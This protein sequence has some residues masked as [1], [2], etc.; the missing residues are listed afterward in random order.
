M[1]PK[2]L[3]GGASLLAA[4]FILALPS[5]FE[6]EPANE[7]E[8]IRFGPPPVARLGEAVRVT[9]PVPRLLEPDL[10]APAFVAPT[11]DPAVASGGDGD[12][13]ATATAG[14]EQGAFAEDAREDDTSK[15]GDEDV[16]EGGSRSGG[17]DEDDD[18]GEDRGD[19]DGDGDKADD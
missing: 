11:T 4:A 9:L 5:I 15:T 7:V 13:G 19:V 3:G 6:G 2:L 1:G 14:A 17:D 12:R 18:V 8:P 16:G 10:P